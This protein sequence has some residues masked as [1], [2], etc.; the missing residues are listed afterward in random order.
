M[1]DQK[2]PIPRVCLPDL[3]MRPGAKSMALRLPIQGFGKNLLKLK[4]SNLARTDHGRVVLQNG[5]TGQ[6]GGKVNPEKNTL[7]IA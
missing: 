6:T 3:E 7:S 1:P 5:C 4:K 2:Y